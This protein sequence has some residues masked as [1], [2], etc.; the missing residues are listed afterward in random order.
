MDEPRIVEL[1]SHPTVAVR[2][3][4]PFRELDLGAVFARELPRLA[5]HLVRAGGSFGGAP[6][7]RYHA[8]GETVD[9]E[10]GIPVAEPMDGPAPLAEVPGG[11][12]GASELPGGP[13]AVV[14]HRGPY[15][16]L[17][18]TYDLLRAWIGEQGRAAGPGP[19]ES[20]IDDPAEV[21]GPARL[22][23]EVVWPLGG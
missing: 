22:R 8:M 19:W 21:S 16:T 12:I 23:T 14:I 20:Y 3:A 6:F 17:S 11:E 1:E 9:V 5:G 7:G 2:L 4:I 15:D 13:A 18:G 10:V